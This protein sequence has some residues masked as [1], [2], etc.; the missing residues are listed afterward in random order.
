MRPVSLRAPSSEAFRTVLGAASAK[1]HLDARSTRTSA[2][3]I[4]TST[5]GSRPPPIHRQNRPDYL[6]TAKAQAEAVSGEIPSSPVGPSI[7]F[8]GFGGG[9][10]NG[11][12]DAVLTTVFGVA[13]L[14]AGGIVY[15]A[16]YKENVLWKIE[17]AFEAGYDPALELAKVSSNKHAPSILPEESGDAVLEPTDAD[18]WWTQH[19]RRSEQDLI[20]H[21]IQ[22]NEVGHYF[23]LLGPKGTGKTTMVLDA[24]QA[25]QAEGVAMCDAHPDLEVFRLRLGKALNYEYNEDTQTGLFQRRDPREGGPA[26]DIERAL[27][28]L[29]KVALRYV[30]KK[31][32]PLILV[33][34]NVHYF[35]HDDEGRNILLQFQQRA[36]AWAA[37]GILT[38]VFS[39]DDAWPF[40]VMRKHASRMHVVSVYDLSPAD[41]RTAAMRMRMKSRRLKDSPETFKEVVR[42]VGGRLTYLGKVTKASDMIAYAEHLLAVEKAWLL[43]QIGLIPDCDDDVMD[44]QKWS[45]CSWLLLREFV[46]K[47]HESVQQKKEEIERGEATEDE[48]NNLPLPRISYYECRRI[49]TRAD[50]M[51]GA[52]VALVWKDTCLNRTFAADLDR[53][54]I[55]S[56]DINHDVSPDSMLIL[57]AAEQVVAE[58]GFDELLD[59]VRDRIDEIESLHRTR[60]L[61]FKDIDK[62]DSIRLAVDKGGA[63]LV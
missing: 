57:H 48:L 26:L 14:F 31:G 32:K 38:M 37:S 21:I 33:L 62:G 55:V 29:E 3:C 17:K 30:H 51:D 63:R 8:G 42:L 47:H 19:L 7:G 1:R 41:A 54:N 34:N 16:W 50:F 39:T 4:R 36:E 13:I 46:K 11:I 12:R 24:M 40:F 9:G 56:I 20:D 53:K 61:T 60:E 58:E 15:M 45:S 10:G 5:A 28:K 44:E 22:G 49:M 52:D 18:G 25:V 6:L 2:R 43:S 59:N 27:N 35:N 23:I